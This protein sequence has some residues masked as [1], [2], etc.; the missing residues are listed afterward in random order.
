MWVLLDPG[1]EQHIA[2]GSL[3]LLSR[4]LNLALRLF[5]LPLR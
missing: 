5:E 1:V 4:D 2:H 3:H